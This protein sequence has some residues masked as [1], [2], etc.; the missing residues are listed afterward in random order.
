[1][2]FIL[3]LGASCSLACGPLFAAESRPNII[4]LMGDDHGWEETG[5]QRPSARE[6]A[7]A[8]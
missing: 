6:D 2:K 7:R 8:R 3:T 1:M 4:L 5:Y